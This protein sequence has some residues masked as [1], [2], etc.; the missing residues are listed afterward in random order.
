MIVDIF[1]FVVIYV[2]RNSLLPLG[3]LYATSKSH[4]D[5][6]VFFSPI[7]SQTAIMVSLHTYASWCSW[8]SWL[9]FVFGLFWCHTYDL[10]LNVLRDYSWW[11]WGT[12]HDDKEQIQVSHMQS[13]WCPVVLILC[14]VPVIS[15]QVFPIGLFK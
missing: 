15:L 5:L 8:E 12:F 7:W 13:K 3:C 6:S 10:L 11:G 4:V 14:L 9:S 1:L 2:F